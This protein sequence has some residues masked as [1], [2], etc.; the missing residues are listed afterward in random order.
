MNI[1]QTKFN[2]DQLNSLD[3]SAYVDSASSESEEDSAAIEERKK[4]LKGLVSE[5]DNKIAKIEVDK[6]KMRAVE[7]WIKIIKRN[8]FL[9]DIF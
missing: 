8:N 9:K 5:F 3:Y 1:T 4:I 7:V 6:M 2:K